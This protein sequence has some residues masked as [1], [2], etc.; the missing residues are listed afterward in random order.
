[1][2]A[3]ANQY[4]GEARLGRLRE[5]H[6]L[7]HIG[8]VVAGK[9]DD[10]GPPAPQ[11]AKIRAMVLDLQ[12]DEADLVPGST[13]R[14][15]DELEPERLEAEKHLGVHQGSG[16]DA[17]QPHGRSLLAIHPSEPEPAERSG[18]PWPIENRVSV[19]RRGPS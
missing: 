10:I 5:V 7:G 3:D 17:E 18:V 2:P 12:I 16:M 19:R 1:M 13:Q 9:R 14:L 11:Q 6:D 15:R 8:E 4:I